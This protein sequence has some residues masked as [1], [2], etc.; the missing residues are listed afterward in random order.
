VKRETRGK[1]KKTEE[2]EED[3]RSK[4]WPAAQT[5]TAERAEKKRRETRDSEERYYDYYGK[6]L[7]QQGIVDPQQ[8]WR[9]R[10]RGLAHLSP[11][12]G[13]GERRT[14][15]TLYRDFCPCETLWPA[16]EFR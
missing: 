5:Q 7:Q 2:E 11:A 12:V 10:M 4:S 13:S 8:Q 3:E 14:R 6:Q 1:K 15:S 16:R 9:R